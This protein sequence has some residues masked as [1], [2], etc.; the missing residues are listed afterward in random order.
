MSS[1]IVV[2]TDWSDGS[3]GQIALG[4]WPSLEQAENVVRCEV[5]FGVSES[6]LMIVRLAGEAPEGRALC[7]GCGAL[8]PPRECPCMDPWV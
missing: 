7:G 2:K 3:P 6:D 4:P 1:F 5:F 8:T